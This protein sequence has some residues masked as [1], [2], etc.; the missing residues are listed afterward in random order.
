MGRLFPVTFFSMKLVLSENSLPQ[1]QFSVRNILLGVNFREG[2][3]FTSG[4]I[5]GREIIFLWDNFLGVRGGAVF[6][7]AV[8]VLGAIFLLPNFGNP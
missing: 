8:F 2:C 4:Q 1:G 5:P 7:R 3:F 6:W